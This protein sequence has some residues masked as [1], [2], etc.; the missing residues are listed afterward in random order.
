MIPR[1]HR[2]TA[3]R[4][5][6]K[7]S[8]NFAVSFDDGIVTVA[9]DGPITPA[10]GDELMRLSLQGLC[11]H[12]V[13]CVLQDMR[14]APT[15][16]S[17]LHIIKRPQQAEEMGFPDDVRVALLCKVV[18]TDV[19]MLVNLAHARGHA[20]RAFTDGA[21]AIAW[22]KADRPGARVVGARAGR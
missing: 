6:K 21:Q 18:S 3:A 15:A 20:V 9:V 14:R 4:P 11:E 12:G 2:M 10:A 1:E 8:A 19:E 13:H 22:L 16:E 5:K 17:T 7:T